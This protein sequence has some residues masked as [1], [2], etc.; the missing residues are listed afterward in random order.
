M[1]D[2][3]SARLD[4]IAT[5]LDG[6]K[7]FAS[8]D[9]LRLNKFDE[10]KE[11]LE[12]D[13]KL[14]ARELG[15][16]INSANDKTEDLKYKNNDPDLIEI[17]DEIVEILKQAKEISLKVQTQV[18]AAI[19]NNR[20]LMKG[21]LRIDETELSK[22]AVKNFTDTSEKIG[23]AIGRVRSAIQI[24]QTSDD[25][26]QAIEEWK[27]AWQEYW[28]AIYLPSLE[29]FGDYVDIARGLATRDYKFD[30]EICRLADDLISRWNL[31]GVSLT[32]PVKYEALEKTVTRIVRLSHRDWTAWALPMVAREV[33]YVI[34]SK[35][36]A[37]EKINNYIA[38]QVIA[39]ANETHLRDYLADIFATY[40]MGPSYGYA[41][42]Y[43][44]FDPIS[45]SHAHSPHAPDVRRAEVIFRMLEWVSK[46][47]MKDDPYIDTYQSLQ[48]EWQNVMRQAGRMELLTPEETQQIAGWVAALADQVYS[49]DSVGLMYPAVQWER[50]IELLDGFLE[51]HTFSRVN[52]TSDDLRSVLNAAWLVRLQWQKQDKD[53]SIQEIETAAKDAM[54]V[55]LG[56][57]PPPVKPQSKQ[58][59]PTSK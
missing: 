25:P 55:I 12:T 37:G 10:L 13:I 33:S 59:I 44:R 58:P 52:K 1:K 3:L 17:I 9:Q 43:L 8:L 47:K 42:V 29:L 41:A 28:Q 39:G 7:N 23:N 15:Y 22:I 34:H 16:K 32:I 27:D 5:N 11:L 26:N 53:D 51:D 48:A 38:E 21:R 31:Q 24:A 4:I 18:T 30:D 36:N 35:E 54:D 6:M 14:P 50:A 56:R 57:V 2:I 19:D 46:N 49:Q 45:A 40:V 20:W